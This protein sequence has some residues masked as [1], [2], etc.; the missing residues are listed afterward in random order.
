MKSLQLLTPAIPC[1]FH[2]PFCIAQSHDHQNQFFNA[3]QEQHDY[4]VNCLTE[5]IKIAS[6]LKTVVI[7]GTNEPLQSPACVQEMIQIV[8]AIRPDVQIELQTRYYK[9]LPVMS[10]CDVVAYSIAEPV[11]LD[12]VKPAGKQNRYVILLTDAFEVMTLADIL[13][14]LPESVTQ[15]TFKQLQHSHGVNPEMDQWIFEHGMTLSKREA[16]K[17]E[18]QEY[19]GMIS[20]FFDEDCMNAENRYMVFREDGNLYPD[21][22][23]N[24]VVMS[25]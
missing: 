2:C 21:Y 17:Q 6:D 4:W 16:L 3:Y 23:T 13:A 11:F 22:D 8:R 5:V 25:R 15:L 20:I 18:V 12:R 10:E 24:E 14:S 7:T 19:Q 9:P 1:I